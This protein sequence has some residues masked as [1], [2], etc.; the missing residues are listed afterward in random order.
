[1]VYIWLR[2]TANW[3]DEA[4]FR[5]QLDPR[6]EP[7]VDVWNDTFDVPFHRFRH[8]IR[9][10][11]ELNLSRVEHA[12]VAS[13]DEIPT[14]AL[15]LPVDDDDW[16]APNAARVLERHLAPEISG[17]FWIA[18]FLEVPINFGHRLALYRRAIFPRT[19]LRWTCSTNNY[20]IVK[21]SDTKLLLENHMAASAWFDG[22]GK[23]RV[24]RIEERLSV[25][26]RTLASRTSLG[27]GRP[28]IRPRELIRKLRRYRALYS[29]PLAPGLEWCRPYVSMM[30]DLVGRL[31]VR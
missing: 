7:K 20:A 28:S 18:S 14:G 24:R 5:A 31:H 25:M 15:V 10:I 23:D 17:Y 9:R 13:F 22:V 8:E 12:A 19:P 1:M 21:R 2:E 4:A 3:Q 29:A 30:A 16:F 11:A 26:N 27:F 6:F